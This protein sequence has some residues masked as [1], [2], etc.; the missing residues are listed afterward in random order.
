MYTV[1][2]TYLIR[3]QCPSDMNI[4]NCPLRNYLHRQDLFRESINSGLLEG[5]KPYATARDEYI[6]AIDAMNEICKK[7]KQQQEH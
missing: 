3:E 2:T 6:R 4:S 7:C 1:Y 5:T